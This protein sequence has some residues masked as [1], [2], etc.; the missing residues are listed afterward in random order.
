MRVLCATT[1]N[2]G[3][4]GPLLPFA[5]ALAG[6]GHEVRV[7]AP[8]SYAHA[9][10]AAGFVHEPC[11]DAPPELIG[12]VMG[13]LPSMT[14]EEADDVVIREVFARIDAQAAL[15]AAIE[16]LER[17][18]PDLVVRESAELS[19]LA[20]AERAGVPHVH[21]CI[22]MHEVVSRF[23]EAD[24]RPAGGAGSARRDGRRPAAG[25]ARLGDDPESRPGGA[26]RARADRRRPW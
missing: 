24:R 25:G 15:P 1:A 5:R 4:F 19:S 6:A 18:R 11:A 21:V 17:W 10:A 23:A 20:A 12:P 9:V 26:R 16:T 13:S 14:L 8:E 22:G 7:L 2:D 3:H